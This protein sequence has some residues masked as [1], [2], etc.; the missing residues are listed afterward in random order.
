VDSRRLHPTQKL[1]TRADG[2]AVQLLAWKSLS[3]PIHF[4]RQ[5]HR[6]QPALLAMLALG[7]GRK[8][9]LCLCG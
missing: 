4:L 9:A 1:H 5:V 2:K 8:P 3:H 6:V 7:C